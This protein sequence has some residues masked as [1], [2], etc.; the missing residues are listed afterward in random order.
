MLAVGDL[1]SLEEMRDLG[2]SGV[3]N[4]KLAP[5]TC[6]NPIPKL[7][8]NHVKRLTSISACGV[9]TKIASLPSSSMGAS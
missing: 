1:K 3:F 9:K 8:L 5:P 6:R 7:I 2:P 4:C